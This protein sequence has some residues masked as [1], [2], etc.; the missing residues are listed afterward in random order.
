MGKK[1]LIVGGVAGG[2]SVAA[3]VR[4]LDESAEIVMFE[5]GPYVSFSN[6]C[7]PFHISGDIEKSESLVLMTPPEFDKQYN[8]DARVYNEV[9]AINKEEKTVSVKNVQTGETYEEAYDVL[10]LAPGANAVR[11][12]SIAGIDSKHV[13][14]M[15]TVPD[16]AALTAYTKANEVKDVAVVGGGYIGLEVAENLKM[17]GYNVSLIEAQDQ[18]MAPLDYDMVQII[19]REIM[20]NGV[21][22]I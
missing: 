10:F 3:R 21:D 19:N 15:K 14:V 7:I 6:C 11:P 4:R 16:V 22:L 9:V 12:R 1:V 13:F 17:A 20:K 2:A 5:R 8:I 18:I